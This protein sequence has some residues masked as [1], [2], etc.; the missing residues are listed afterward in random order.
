MTEEQQKIFDIQCESTK[1][2][3]LAQMSRPEEDDY[4]YIAKLRSTPIVKEAQ[5]LKEDGTVDLNV[6][7]VSQ[8][9]ETLHKDARYK[10]GEIIARGREATEPTITEEKRERGAAAFMRAFSVDALKHKFKMVMKDLFKPSHAEIMA[11][12]MRKVKDE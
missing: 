7:F 11:E 2:L 3:M 8:A 6:R 5:C 9:E 4:L 1:A 12:A 10:R